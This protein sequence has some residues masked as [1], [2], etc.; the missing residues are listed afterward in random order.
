MS[1]EKEYELLQECNDAKVEAI[2]DDEAHYDIEVFIDMFVSDEFIEEYLELEA[3]C[4]EY[5]HYIRGVL[6]EI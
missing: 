6:K 1:E 4:K 2:M 3:K 5:G